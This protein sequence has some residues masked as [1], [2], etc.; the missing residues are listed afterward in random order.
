MGEN[1]SVKNTEMVQKNS[2]DVQLSKP[3]HNSNDYSKNHER[4]VRTISFQ[5]NYNNK[6]IK[7]KLKKKK[8]GIIIILILIISLIALILS[9]Y[10]DF[11][12][13][14]YPAII[15]VSLIIFIFACQTEKKP[16]M[17]TYRLT[18]KN[19]KQKKGKRK[20]DELPPTDDPN[21]EEDPRYLFFGCKHHC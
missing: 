9:K 14:E 4:K 1:Q 18:S 7:T 6:L 16:T 13:S 8:I 11:F 20:L 3:I 10:T 5:E 2:S 21:S 19:K 15:I 12:Q 17:R